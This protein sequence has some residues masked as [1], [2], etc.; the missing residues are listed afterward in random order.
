MRFRNYRATLYRWVTAERRLGVVLAAV[1]L[2]IACLGAAMYVLPGP[3]FPLLVIGLSLFL[4]GV[5]M[6][7]AG[8]DGER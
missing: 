8:R 3:G 4:T 6:A 5:V 2:P 1:G 7:L